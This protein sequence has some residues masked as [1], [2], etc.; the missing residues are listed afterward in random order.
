MYKFGLMGNR[1]EINTSIRVP[2]L[3]VISV[4]YKQDYDLP[5]Y[6]L[7]T[8]KSIASDLLQTLGAFG[9]AIDS[10]AGLYISKVSFPDRKLYASFDYEKTNTLAAADRVLGLRELWP[11]NNGGTLDVKYVP[12]N[13]D[14]STM[15]SRVMRAHNTSELYLLETTDTISGKANG[16][17]VLQ[18]EYNWPQDWHYYEPIAD[19]KWQHI[20]TKYISLRY[21]PAIE[22][23]ITDQELDKCWPVNVLPLSWLTDMDNL[24]SPEIGLEYLMRKRNEGRPKVEDMVAFTFYESDNYSMNASIVH[25]DKV[26][27][28]SKGEYVCAGFSD[29]NDILRFKGLNISD[30]EGRS[31]TVKDTIKCAF[32]YNGHAYQVAKYL[33]VELDYNEPF[34]LEKIDDIFQLVER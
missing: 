5:F 4:H 9:E 3:A 30:N 27:L 31:I 21:R 16:Y 8:R 2:Q 29:S 13:F 6:I 24:P 33:P 7:S 10:S 26:L 34:E 23:G 15:Y 22:L 1:R 17:L 20:S 14:I 25:V 18:N 19:T 11:L 28:S 32:E 12:I